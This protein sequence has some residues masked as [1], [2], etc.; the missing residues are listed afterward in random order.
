MTVRT[1]RYLG[2]Q[3]EDSGG[4]PIKR[5]VEKRIVQPTPKQ[6]FLSKLNESVRSK[7]VEVATCFLQVPNFHSVKA[8]QR[9][10]LDCYC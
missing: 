10:L 5:R 8:D 6:Y 1:F 7:L 4:H 2:T 3:V 9:R